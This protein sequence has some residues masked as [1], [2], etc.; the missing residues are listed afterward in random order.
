V[1]HNKLV[2]SPEVQDKLFAFLNVSGVV[3]PQASP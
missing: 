1:E 3:V 2:T